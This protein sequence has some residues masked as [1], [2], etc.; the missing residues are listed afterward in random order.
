MTPVPMPNMTIRITV[1]MIVSHGNINIH[2]MVPIRHT[3][4]IGTK[5]VQHTSVI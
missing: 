3:N 5:Y 2:I 1:P 4:D